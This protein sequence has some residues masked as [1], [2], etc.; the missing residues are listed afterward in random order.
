MQEVRSNQ[1]MQPTAVN[2]MHV[3]EIRSRSDQRGVDLISDVL[4]FGRLWYDTPDNA[5]G[6][7]L[8]SSRSHN[9]VIRVYDDAGDMIETHEHMGDFKEW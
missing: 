4:P 9:A 5:I 2:S 1:A 8:H 6:Y 7:A 3:Y